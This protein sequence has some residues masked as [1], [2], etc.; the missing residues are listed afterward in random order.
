MGWE[1][2]STWLSNAGEAPPVQPDP[3]AMMI[4]FFAMAMRAFPKSMCCTDPAPVPVNVVGGDMFSS[5]AQHVCTAL[6]IKQNKKIG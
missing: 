5:L 6:A 4:G 1:G 3:Q 2:L